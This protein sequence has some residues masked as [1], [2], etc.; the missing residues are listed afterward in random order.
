MK[1]SF[2]MEHYKEIC[3]L[4]SNSSY[5]SIFF[6][7]AYDKEENVII[8]RHDVDQSLESSLEL[9]KI[10]EEKGLKSVYFIW[11]TSPFYNNF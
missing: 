9:A 2:T 4:I 10:E 3:E 6:D 11:L 1:C 8:L 5:R 7:E